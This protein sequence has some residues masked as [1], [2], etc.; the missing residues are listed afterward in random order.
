MSKGFQGPGKH[1]KKKVEPNLL[2]TFLVR[3]TRVFRIANGARSA[4]RCS[5]EKSIL[6]LN[7]ESE[8]FILLRQE[9]I[10]RAEQRLMGNCILIES[11]QV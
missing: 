8:H 1:D 5:Q 9:F 7:Q 3:G 10:N 11:R 4:G 2:A 6:G